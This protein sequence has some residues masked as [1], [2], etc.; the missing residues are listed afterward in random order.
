[1][2]TSVAIEALEREWRVKQVR[3]LCE[4][5]LD[6]Y[7]TA[8]T[9][10]KARWI[11][12]ETAQGI[13][14]DLFQTL[15]LR[16]PQAFLAARTELH[17]RHRLIRTDGAKAL[18]LADKRDA[19]RLASLVD[20]FG[21][22]HYLDAAR[23]VAGNSS[24]GVPRF[25]VL[26]EN[27]DAEQFLLDLKQAGP[28]VALGFQ[29]GPAQPKWKSHA[30]RVVE[31]Q[32]MVQAIPPAFLRAVEFDGASWVLRE[33]MPGED[34]VDVAQ[35]STPK[36][37]EHA[38]SLG[39]V[40]AWGHL[41]SGGRLGSATIDALIHFGERRAWRSAIARYAV[42]YAGRVRKDWEKFC[43]EYQP[44]KKKARAMSRN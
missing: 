11:E 19:A 16:T 3:D 39:Q 33:L 8:L 10:G 4:A 20:S 34:R 26:V 9:S 27:K 28:P 37:I 1:M 15:G 31:V 40:V 43:R 5:L 25:V 32:S 21:R 18:P 36:F 14:Q 41:R 7:A 44:A 35:A 24:L 29:S 42:D 12:R 22:F 23:R 17:R 6:S 2:V 38:K 30:A 13:V